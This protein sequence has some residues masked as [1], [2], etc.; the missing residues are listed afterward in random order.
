MTLM[1]G[2]RALLEQLVADGVQ[3]VFGNP[4]TTEQAFQDL[5]QEY[6]QLTYVLCLHEGVAVSMAD[7]YARATGRP[8]VVQ[9]HIAPGLGNAMGMLYN[10]YASHS[11]LVV[12]VGQSASESLVQ[13][14]LLS[15]DLV[16]MAKP[17]SKWA[18]QVE[19]A[20]DVAHV[21][22]RAHDLAAQPPR[23]PV[24]LAI[25]IDTMEAEAE[26]DV[27]PT[28][29]TRWHTPPDPTALEEAA[30]L[31]AA[32]V[33]P[34]LIVG[35]GVALSGAQQEVADLAVTLGAPVWL[36]YST[37]VNIDALHPHV[38]GTLPATSASAST[39]TDRLLADHDAV[40]VLGS[41]VFRFIFPKPG[42][43]VP[44]GV[45]V[46][47]VDLDGWEL[48]KNVPG[49]LGIRGDVRSSAIR[50]RELL[51]ELPDAARRAQSITA[52]I[53][54]T[55]QARLDADAALT[56]EAAIPVALA[57]RE[58]AAALPDDVAI[59]E[60]AMTSAAA[61]GRHVPVH[62]GRYFRARGGGIGPGIP[63]AVGLKLAMPDRPVVGVVS[64]G[65]GLYSITA[66]WTAAHHRVPV[67]WVV[68][69]NGTYRILKENL[70]E[71]LGDE[72]AGR[73]FVEL[74]LADPPLRY[75][76]IARAFG[77]TAE[78]VERLEDL[79]PAVRRAL[80]LGS[81]ALVEVLVSGAV[82]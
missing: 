59:F 51:G 42:S 32:S 19:H 53:A 23:G 72:R 3:Y 41:P 68:I 52:A 75:D 46:V 74:D 22:R 37:E 14:P 6:P 18:V 39:V 1:T 4:G 62:P 16:A 2:K 66:L 58:L 61:F 65:S 30:A 40:L 80:T 50:L 28:S 8:A 71:Y 31:L 78:R 34:L 79:G 82:D 25:P 7:A 48:G 60:E 26:V 11:S 5:L 55:R 47:H 10:A 81:P 15:A 21:V 57:M 69:N 27:Q 73:Q 54:E 49:V 24:V 56:A 38:A 9:L 17:I 36:G 44:A 43:P 76:E 33:N 20:G 67:V 12:Y 77:V 64:D 13:E 45:R 70:V 29:Y 63:G 35:D